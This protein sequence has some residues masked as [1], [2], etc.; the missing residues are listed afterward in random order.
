MI[1][2]PFS[3]CKHTLPTNC[4]I[5]QPYFYTRA[6]K[7]HGSTCWKQGAGN[8][9]GKRVQETSPLRTVLVP[10]LTLAWK[11]LLVSR[12]MFQ[13]CSPAPLTWELSTC[14]IGCF[15]PKQKCQMRRGE[16][17]TFSSHRVSAGTP[18]EGHRTAERLPRPCMHCHQ[19]SQVVNKATSGCATNGVSKVGVDLVLRRKKALFKSKVL[20]CWSSQAVLGMLQVQL[21]TCISS[22]T[23]H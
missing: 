20:T 21:Q 14:K 2:I 16:S 15:L 12:N 10:V 19:L 5:T 8:L 11:C 13:P 1:G 7:A 9:N 4:P 3:L 6:R 22:E 23:K 18:K 17:G